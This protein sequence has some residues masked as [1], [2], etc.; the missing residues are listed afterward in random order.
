[1]S[2]REFM[3]VYLSGYTIVQAQSQEAAAQMFRD[4]PHFTM[5]PGDSV[6]IME[7]LPLPLD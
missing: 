5:F 7:I 4:H 6:E 3:A 2:T 1:M